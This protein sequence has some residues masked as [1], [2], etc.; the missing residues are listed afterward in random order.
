MSTTAGFRI[1]HDRS[2]MVGLAA[3]TTCRG[4]T[5]LSPG[6][7]AREDETVEST[8][9]RTAM[10]AYVTLREITPDNRDAIEALRVAGGQENFVSDVS[11]SLSEAA[12][13]P[14]AKP[15]Y[16]A[17]YAGEAPV[18]FLMLGDDVPPGNPVI[19]WPYYLWRMLIDGRYQGR[20]YGRAALDRLVEYLKTRPGAQLLVTSI[21]PGEGSPL[22]FYLR[23][24]FEPT[25]QMFDHEQ[26]LQLRLTE[27]AEEE[28][29]SDGRQS[30]GMATDS[31][32][33]N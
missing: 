6:W 2:L 33:A 27:P 21:V 23:Y 16:R 10:S 9:P 1:G 30:A 7:I 20:G 28:C 3:P 29:S 26:V 14:A 4:V 24:G 25:G 11:Q 19:P 17:V 12:A 5:P 31:E 32:A 13:T 15:W 18:G 8:E 22:G